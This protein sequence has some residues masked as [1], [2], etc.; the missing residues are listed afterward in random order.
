M[1]VVCSVT[2]SV[3]M[4]LVVLLLCVEASTLMFLYVLCVYRRGGDY[5]RDRD[6]DRRDRCVLVCRFDYLWHHVACYAWVSF[7]GCATGSLSSSPLGG[8]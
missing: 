3:C 8:C 4:R 7:S 2:F 1:L 5:D 6:Y